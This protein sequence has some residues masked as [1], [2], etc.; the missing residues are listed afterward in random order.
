MSRQCGSLNISQPYR[1]PQPVTGITLL[2]LVSFSARES[3]ARSGV[4]ATSAARPRMRTAEA[5]QRSRTDTSR[6]LK[7]AELCIVPRYWHGRNVKVWIRS[8]DGRF[9]LVCAGVTRER[10]ALLASPA[11]TCKGHC[12]LFT[13]VAGFCS[14][15]RPATIMAIDLCL[16]A[17]TRTNSVPFKVFL[18]HFVSHVLRNLGNLTKLALF[19]TV[20]P[21]MHTIIKSINLLE[22]SAVIPCGTD[23]RFLFSTAFSVDVLTVTPSSRCKP[24]YFDVRP[25]LFRRVLSP[26]FSDSKNKFHLLPASSWLL[27]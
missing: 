22:G 15:Q 13:S 10:E 23:G 18:N 11:V 16:P 2:S 9:P 20:N 12:L 24:V 4:S 7:I 21:R 17:H 25:S 3:Q 8:G 14:H 5:D 1:P 19:P 27:V 6:T 26:P